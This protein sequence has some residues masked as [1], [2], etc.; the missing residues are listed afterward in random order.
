[1]SANAS[2]APTTPTLMDALFP[3]SVHAQDSSATPMILA[4]I[5]GSMLSSIGDAIAKL[6]IIEKDLI[7]AYESSFNKVDIEKAS[8]QT[9]RN[10]PAFLSRLNT[11]QAL[12]RQ[13]PHG[14]V[15]PDAGDSLDDPIHQQ[16]A[17]FLAAIRGLKTA[18][19]LQN[20]GLGLLKKGLEKL[21]ESETFLN[22]EEIG[23][24]SVGDG[25]EGVGSVNMEEGEGNVKVK[26]EE[27]E[28][29]SK[30]KPMEK[31]S[32]NEGGELER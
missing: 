6:E 4:E 2:G 1:M 3:A 17:A 32:G 14:D 11:G 16:D 28:G 27:E 25:V 19:G 23:C 30:M 5:Q 22:G 21:R 26:T 10:M 9:M 7:S 18:L 29:S 13:G 24:A 31:Y 20:E 15:L 8:Q 12:Q